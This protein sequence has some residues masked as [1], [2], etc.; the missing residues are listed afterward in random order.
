MAEGRSC[1]WRDPQNIYAG[2]E[3]LG[4]VGSLIEVPAAMTHLS[5]V[6]SHWKL[7]PGVVRLSVGIENVDD[8]LAD[9][10]QALK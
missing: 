10:E 1:R 9:L 5:V 6:G 7:T 8:L 3:S 2:R 4:G